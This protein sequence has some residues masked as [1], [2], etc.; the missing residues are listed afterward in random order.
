MQEINKEININPDSKNIIILAGFSTITI[1]SF[2]RVIIYIIFFMNYLE[3]FNLEQYFNTID[4]LKKF[5]FKN[6]EKILSYKVEKIN[7]NKIKVGFVTSDF[8]EHAVGYQIF[9]V[10]KNLSDSSNKDIIFCYCFNRNYSTII[11]IG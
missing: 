1:F 8:R 10:I 3:N 7:N 5:F 4:K 2:V 9:E 11:S 6:K